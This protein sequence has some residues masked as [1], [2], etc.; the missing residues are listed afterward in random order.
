[1]APDPNSASREQPPAWEPLKATGIPFC[2]YSSPTEA[3]HS[4]TIPTQLPER[5]AAQPASLP[6]CTCQQPSIT[7]LS[8]APALPLPSLPSLSHSL[9]VVQ[10][11]LLCLR[12]PAPLAP[13]PFARAQSQT[14]GSSEEKQ[15]RDPS[16][17]HRRPEPGRT[18]RQR[19][20]WR[21]SPN[22]S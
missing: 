1:M 13:Q 17:L 7:C 2:H 20:R 22:P 10:R 14:W 6:I 4:S 15:Q 18:R 11:K 16:N 8:T 21:R 3:S 9:P 19:R 12:L 5:A